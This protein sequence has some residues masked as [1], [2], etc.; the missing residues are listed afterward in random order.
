[1]VKPRIPSPNCINIF[2]VKILETDNSLAQHHQNKKS[3]N[4][5]MLYLHK[6]NRREKPFTLKTFCKS[7]RLSNHVSQSFLPIVFPK[8]FSSFCVKA[9]SLLFYIKLYDILTFETAFLPQIT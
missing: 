3:R 8:L 6:F 4:S 9:L 2:N 1:M 5:L 7:K